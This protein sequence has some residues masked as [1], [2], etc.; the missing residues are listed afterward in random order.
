MDQALKDELFKPNNKIVV[1]FE[2]ELFSDI[3]F[4]K[5]ASVEDL[6]SLEFSPDEEE[7]NFAQ[8]PIFQ[9]L[10]VL[11]QGVRSAP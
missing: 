2:N 1:K 11:S 4:S 8:D 9:D 6:K 7:I 3:A 10:A 5:S